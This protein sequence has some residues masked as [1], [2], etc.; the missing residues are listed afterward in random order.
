MLQG[1]KP[2]LQRLGY[3]AIGALLGVIFSSIVIYTQITV[4]IAKNDAKIE[5]VKDQLERLSSAH[6][7]SHQGQEHGE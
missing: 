2:H 6:P 1:I 3:I 5:A 4:Q 7:V